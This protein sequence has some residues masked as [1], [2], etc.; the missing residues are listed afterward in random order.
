MLRNFF[1]S[2]KIFDF[3]HFDLENISINVMI[4]HLNTLL[5]VNEED[6]YIKVLHFNNQVYIYNF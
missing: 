5:D 1:T 2:K 4:R 6:I 3:F